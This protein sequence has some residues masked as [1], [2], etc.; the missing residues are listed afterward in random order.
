MMCFKG[1]MIGVTTFLTDDNQKIEITFANYNKP[2][3]GVNIYLSLID[4]KGWYLV[5]DFVLA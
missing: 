1:K 3:M 4:K 2:P 5:D